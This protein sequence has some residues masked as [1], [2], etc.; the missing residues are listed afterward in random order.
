M[1][2]IEKPYS[3]YY[4][5]TS[6][7]AKAYGLNA[8]NPVYVQN[9][10]VPES[11]RK[12]GK[13]TELLKEIEQFAKDNKADLI[14]GYVSD[15][16]DKENTLQFMNKRG[17][18][19]QENGDFYKVVSSENKLI[20][21]QKPIE[22]INTKNFD[23][24]EKGQYDFSKVDIMNRDKKNDTI[25]YVNPKDINEKHYIDYPQ[26]AL[27]NK[28]N[29]KEDRIM[30]VT[31]FL[32][33]ELPDCSEIERDGEI[34]KT[35]F[36]APIVKFDDKGKLFIE[37]GRHR[38]LV[39]E[40]MGFNKFPI[41]VPKGQVVKFNE[42]IMDDSKVF[43]IN[44]NGNYLYAQIVEPKFSE[45]YKAGKSKNPIYLK[46]LYVKESDRRTGIGTDMLKRLDDFAIKNNVDIIFGTVAKNATYKTDDK[47]N[48]LPET[49]LIKWWLHE[50][51]YAINE[52]NNDFHKVVGSGDKVVGKF[53]QQPNANTSWWLTRKVS[54]YGM[55]GVIQYYVLYGSNSEQF[56][57]R[58]EIVKNNPNYNNKDKF[59]RELNLELSEIKDKSDEIKNNLQKWVNT[60]GEYLKTTDHYIDST[61]DYMAL[62]ML[63]DAGYKMLESD[64]FLDKKDVEPEPRVQ[65]SFRNVKEGDY[66]EV[67]MG[68]NSIGKG[69]VSKNYSKNYITLN[70]DD[71]QKYGYLY[72]YYVLEQPKPD[73]KKEKALARIRVRRRILELKNR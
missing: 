35:M 5:T 32:K 46:N 16:A 17:F 56:N 18:T 45:D 53:G 39:A 59:K 51:G 55:D 38:L 34:L 19:I 52:D 69:I 10:Y 54:P 42:Y 26:F 66:V 13:G 8:E 44:E 50:R 31:N 9:L 43:E 22:Y 58:L 67:M 61:S 15:K 41:Q 57:K 27:R 11:D 37:D 14:F 30:Q 72:A 65:T 33:E 73:N 1:E 20:P 3:N 25:I 40:Q 4:L 47:P 63:Y 29:V 21:T 2:K 28:E 64:Y 62:D 24:I 48:Y 71:S 68:G 36:T 23:C 60:G 7:H 49:E 70:N 6:E 12:K